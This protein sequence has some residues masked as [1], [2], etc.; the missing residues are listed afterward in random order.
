MSTRSDGVSSI[1]RR[2]D[3]LCATLRLSAA[4]VA[5]VRIAFLRQADAPR[6]QRVPLI[7]NG[8]RRKPFWEAKEL[9]TAVMLE[10]KYGAIRGEF[11]GLGAM[12][13]P[14]TDRKLIESGG[15]AQVHLRIADLLVEENMATCPETAAA[16]QGEPPVG[17]TYFSR[18]APGTKVRGH[19]GPGNYRL[20]IHLGLE[21]P[22]DCGIC[23]DDVTRTWEPGRCLVLDDS[24]YHTVWNNGAMSRS[25]LLTDV[26]HPD[27]TTAEVRLLYGLFSTDDAQRSNNLRRYLAATRAKVPSADAFELR[28]A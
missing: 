18:H 1:L 14:H 27:L 26:W 16:C 2:V 3:D 28:K 8:I 23:V 7:I 12:M 15:W 17:L 5:R 19:F 24:F 10:R 22:E 20:R 9:P 4:E 25:I 6:A 11:L 21:V 13:R